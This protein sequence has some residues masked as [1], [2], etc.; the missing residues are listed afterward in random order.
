MSNIKSRV[1]R[2]IGIISEIF[3][4]LSS[5]SFG[6]NYFLI[7]LL[8][9]ETMLLNAILYNLDVGYDLSARELRELAQIDVLFFT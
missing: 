8:L 5:V 4:I 3:T 6:S 1:S 2:G 7:A 9:R